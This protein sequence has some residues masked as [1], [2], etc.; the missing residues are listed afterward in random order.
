MLRGLTDLIEPLRDLLPPEI[1]IALGVVLAVVAIPMWWRSVT[2]RQIKGH[3][4][5]A[6]RAHGERAREA[7]IEAAFKRTGGKPRALVDLAEHARR[8]GLPRAARRAIDELERT[9]RLPL[10]V[11]RLRRE[12]EPA[13]HSLVDPVQAAVRAER[14]IDLELWTAAHET[15]A[16]ALDRFPDD[17][18]LRALRD[19]LARRG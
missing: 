9:G 17:P 4:R 1:L 2:V 14:M 3:L 8:A 10:E 6:A 18:E 15:L 5:R 12:T 16:E 11:R 19:R 13:D 7:S